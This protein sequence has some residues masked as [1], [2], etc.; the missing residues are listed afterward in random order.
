MIPAAVAAN[1][2][3]A[4][5]VVEALDSGVVVLDAH[6]RAVLVNPAARAMGILEVDR[7]TFPELAG[8][9]DTA[10]ARRRPVTKGIDLPIGRLGR[11][12]IALQVTAVPLAGTGEDRSAS[13]VALL[14]ADIS[15]QRRL[16]AVRRDFVANVSHELKTPVGAL[17]LLA[18]AIQ[19]AADEP[20]TVARFAGRM[21]HE[22]A[23]LNR[24]V[25]ELMELSRVQGVDP[26]PGAASIEV[27]ALV[28]EATDGSRLAAEHAVI[29]VEVRCE[30]G[31]IVRGDDAQL[32]TAIANLVDN[33]IAY[34]PPNTRVVVTANAT[35]D[36]QARVYVDI[37]VTDQGLGIA[38]SDLDRIFE[39][40]Y[41]VDPA[42]SRATGGTGLGLAIVKNIVTNHLGMV[43]VRSVVGSGST[44]TVRLPL[45]H[46]DQ[47]PSAQDGADPLAATNAGQR[48]SA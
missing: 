39:R 13:P 36:A 16:E 14:L 35:T 47:S 32:R 43:S 21:Q 17:T 28:E 29:D 18:E 24:L 12:P 34:S 45:V 2:S 37:A 48:G 11:E 4:S 33:A 31:L 41:R 1:Q 5:L 9:A 38:E 8:L 7:I 6:D 15:E 20:A 23:R 44:F 40:F 25:G 42:R 30:P 10:R 46:S 19:D 26:M 3:L 27:K 22:G